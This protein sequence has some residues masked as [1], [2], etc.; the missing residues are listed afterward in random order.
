MMAGMG[1]G[2]RSLEINPRHPLVAQLKAALAAAG[3]EGDKVAPAAKGAAHLL[4]ET[5]LL[6]SGYAVDD[7][8]V[9]RVGRGGGRWSTGR[10]MPPNLHCTL[11]LRML[12]IVTV[13]SAGCL[14]TVC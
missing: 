5:A 10:K 2:Q 11:M 6:E 14:L 13:D 9:S 12:P 7:V 8:K 1:K 3:G 4:Y